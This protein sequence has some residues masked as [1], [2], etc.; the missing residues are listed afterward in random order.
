M[1]RDY[2]VIAL[3]LVLI[4]PPVV[5]VLGVQQWDRVEKAATRP[6]R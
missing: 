6:A 4:F 5:A 1:Q 2:R 3:I